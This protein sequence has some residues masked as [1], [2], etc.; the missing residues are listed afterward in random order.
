MILEVGV[1]IMLAY[2]QEIAS[3]LLQQVI[4]SISEHVNMY[5]CRLVGNTPE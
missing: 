1:T 2:S 3:M 5:Y 4:V